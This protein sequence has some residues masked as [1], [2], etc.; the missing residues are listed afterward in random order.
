MKRHDRFGGLFWFVVGVGICIGSMN[1]NLGTLHKPGAGFVP[2]LT[3]IVLGVLG[4]ILTWS[5][6][7]KA[8]SEGEEGEKGSKKIIVA[9]TQ[10]RFVFA[11]LALFGYA[12]LL[13]PIG[14]FITTFLFLLLSFK[15]TEA[16]KWV[17]P[18]VL[19]V[20]AVIISYLIFSVWLQLQFPRGIL[21]LFKF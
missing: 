8:L 12:F 6:F 1:L 9:F 4:L 11:L 19:S 3:G 14:F 15:L 21:K 20:S 17:M 5:T 2:F 18:L 10:K 16:K 13:E 7:S